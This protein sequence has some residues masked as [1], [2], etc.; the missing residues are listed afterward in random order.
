MSSSTTDASIAR[1]CRELRRTAW[2]LCA[3]AAI[4]VQG[5][6]V[7]PSLEGRHASSV[8][9]DVGD[10][11][12]AR[13]LDPLEAAHPGLSGL[14]ILPNGPDSFAARMRLA[15]AAERTLD[16]QYYIWH[17]DMTGTLLLSALRRAADRGVRVRL[18]LDDNNT[19]GMDGLLAAMAAYPNMEVR[20]FNPFASRGARWWQYA[21][22]FRRLDRR[23]HNKSFTA[24]NRATI[25]GGRNVGDEY[26]DAGQDLFFVDLDIL[27]VGAVVQDVSRDFDRYWSSDSAYPAER[28]L[29]HVSPDPVASIDAA[30]ARVARAPAAVAYMDALARHPFVKAMLERRL[31][32]EWAAA[33]LVSD[34]PAK[35]LGG[36]G[37][38]EQRLWT[39]LRERLAPPT[40][41]LE[42]VSPYFVPAKADVDALSGLVRDGVNV[43]VVT[44]S[45]EA[46][47][48]PAV[49]AGYIGRRR[50]LLEAG[51][52]LLEVKRASPAPSSA[53]A[54]PGS[55]SGTSLHAKTAS[56]DRARAF[57]GSFNFDPRSKELNTELGFVI[58]SPAIAGE[59]ADAVHSKLA[60]RAYRV[61]LDPGGSLL[62]TEEVDGKELHYVDEPRTTFWQRLRVRLLSLLPIDGLL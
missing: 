53:S 18:L 24:D 39:Q 50:Q 26:F 32:L 12:L 11:R 37:M 43:T 14:V 46:T 5:C 45:L 51:V 13:S 30:A 58:D 28:V 10:T 19:A 23:M 9:T 2:S 33:Q 3:C 25:I 42:L 60:A 38:P 16:V 1:R 59:I 48:V 20:L 34:D 56:I 57:V 27:A 6:A 55:S 8:L 15:D 22:D 35:G 62:W 54:L 41:E 4:L 21:T 52:G 7:L 17:A 47:D 49:H 44:N 29:A 61:S 31:P 36:V 40:R